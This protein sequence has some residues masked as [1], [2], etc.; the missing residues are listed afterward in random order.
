[1][2]WIHN[3]FKEYFGKYNPVCPKKNLNGLI[4][5]GRVTIIIRYFLFKNMDYQRLLVY[6]IYYVLNLKKSDTKIDIIINIDFI[7]Y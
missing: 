5:V 4:C 6:K 3:L 2:T 7:I 1:M